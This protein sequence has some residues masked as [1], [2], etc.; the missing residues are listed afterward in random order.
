MKLAIVGSYWLKDENGK[1]IVTGVPFD[2]PEYDIWVFNEAA[3]NDWC[4]RWD[5]C[6]QMHKPELYKGYNTKYEKHWDWLQEKHDKP[7]IMQA[8]DP[9]VPDSV[10]YPLDEAIALTGYKYLTGTP[11]YAIAYGLLKGYEQID[12]WGVELSDTEYRYQAEALRFWVGYAKGK[13]GDKF[14]MHCA[15]HLFEGRLYGYEGDLAFGKEFFEGRAKDYDARWKSADWNL[16]KIKTKL[17]RAVNGNKY[18]KVP[19]LQQEFHEAAMAVGELAGALA[20][21]ER[22]AAFGDRY[23]DRGHF[24]FSAA[25]AQIEGEKAKA[26]AFIEVGKAEY[27][28]N[29]WRQLKN[30]AALKQMLKLLE[31]V[32]STAYDC[33]AQ[34]GKYQENMEYI[35]QYDAMTTANGKP[36]V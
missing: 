8:V 31:N 30:S 13:L 6:F 17:E 35:R 28:W 15:D 29:A 16:T 34:L 11:A 23:A 4:K 18:D 24:E 5:L 7:I 22:Y 19:A 21:A 27:V 33:G 1:S 32:G 25:T 3:T 36:N 26:T 12:V 2:D 10:A 14:K 20:E 9:Q